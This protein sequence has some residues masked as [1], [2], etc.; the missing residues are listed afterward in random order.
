M[1][2]KQYLFSVQVEHEQ[3]ER[4][5]C[6]VWRRRRVCGPVCYARPGAAA[7][8]ESEWLAAVRGGELGRAAEFLCE[9]R[10]R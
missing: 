4:G 8:K 9:V 7:A 6:K 1:K 2:I 3:Q 10:G 5:N